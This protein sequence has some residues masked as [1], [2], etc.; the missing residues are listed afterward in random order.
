[1]IIIVMLFYSYYSR[2]IL[3]AL[4]VLLCQHIRN[5]PLISSSMYQVVSDG[6]LF[7]QVCGFEAQC[8]S[9]LCHHD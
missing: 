7:S 2:I 1:M 5:I 9:R 4:M 8:E 3:S 6:L